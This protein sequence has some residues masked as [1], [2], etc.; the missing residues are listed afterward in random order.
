M[1]TAAARIDVRR[2]RDLLAAGALALLCAG[3]TWLTG[4]PP[5]RIAGG[6]M[7]EL[8]LPGYAIT[9]LVRD[10]RA[11]RA[12]E[13]LM[14]VIGASLVTAA[15]G[16][17]VLDVLPGHMGHAQWAALL[18]AVTLVAAVLAALRPPPPETA[19]RG[20]E[21]ARS[22]GALLRAPTLKGVANGLIGALALAVAVAGVLVARHAA[23]RQPGFVELST[24]PASPAPG[25]RLHV[26]LASHE[27]HAVGL[28]VIARE[29]GVPMRRWIL[30]LPPGGESRIGVPGPKPTTSQVR[31]DVYRAGSSA[32]YLH[33]TYY[34]PAALVAAA[35]AARR[36][37]AAARPHARA[38]QRRNRG[39]RG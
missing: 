30:S 7:L 32:P 19:A 11:L 21:G 13:L 22:P 28:L 26:R 15:L 18:V 38:V 8:V 3:A 17:I 35:L 25:A 16:G 20:L 39:A 23:N 24:L 31:F 9:A 33:T 6:L 2:D 10:R 36:R 5:L 14:C 12:S 34:Q 29:D 4:T 37:A 27:P 1:S